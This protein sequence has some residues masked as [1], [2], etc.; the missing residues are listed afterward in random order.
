LPAA[1]FGSKTDKL[2][3]IF[4]EAANDTDKQKD[5][6]ERA[7]L[8][9]VKKVRKPRLNGKTER[10]RAILQFDFLS[11]RYFLKVFWAMY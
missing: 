10:P 8:R 7:S 9:G 4:A 5:P 6:P 11:V 1:I 2:D 3:Y